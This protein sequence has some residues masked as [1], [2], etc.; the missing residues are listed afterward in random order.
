M[1]CRVTSLLYSEMA[2][3]TEDA[4]CDVELIYHLKVGPSHLHRKCER[5]GFTTG[6]LH[7]WGSFIFRRRRGFG[8]GK[9]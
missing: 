4:G 6:E 3:V 2:A 7:S 8:S 1:D 5:P 9:S